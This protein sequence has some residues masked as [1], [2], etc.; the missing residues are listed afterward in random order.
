MDTVLF[1]CFG[2]LLGNVVRLIQ[3]SA[4]PPQAH[5]IDFKDPFYYVQLVLLAF[6]GG[7]FVYL[8]D[9]SGMKLTALL[10]VNIGASAPIIAQNFLSAVPPVGSRKVD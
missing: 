5:T 8:Y 6:L 3:T 7:V 4:Q 1:G 10:A 2:G 9:I